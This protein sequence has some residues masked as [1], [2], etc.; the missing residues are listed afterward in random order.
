MNVFNRK[1]SDTSELVPYIT[2]FRLTTREV[3]NAILMDSTY[4]RAGTV[5]ACSPEGF[6][7]ALMA[8]VNFE[9]QDSTLGVLE[10]RLHPETFDI[11]IRTNATPE[12]VKCIWK[13]LVDVD[14]QLRFEAPY[15][16]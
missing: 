11:F 2:T 9:I 7:K 13:E 10:V 14:L 3:D 1:T 8:G 16:E 4:L 12:E 5:A 6:K 15:Y